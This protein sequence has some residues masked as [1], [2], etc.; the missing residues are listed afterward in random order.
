MTFSYTKN[1]EAE[2]TEI[3]LYDVFGSNVDSLKKHI[4]MLLDE[5]KN[6]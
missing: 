2:I 3:T 4:K 5:V 6:D 1:A